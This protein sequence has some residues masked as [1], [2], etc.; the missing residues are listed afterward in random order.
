MDTAQEESLFQFQRRLH[1]AENGERYLDQLKAK[2]KANVQESPIQSSKG[3]VV[4]EDFDGEDPEPSIPS[5]PSVP[6]RS[7][8]VTKIDDFTVKVRGCVCAA[9][10]LLHTP[11][12]EH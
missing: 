3:C 11:V 5:E 6:P 9:A 7:S 8:D 10:E 4:L 1:I 2:K 12:C